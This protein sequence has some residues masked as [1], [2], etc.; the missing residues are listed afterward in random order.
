MLEK[1]VE[2]KDSVK[3]TFGLINKNVPVLSETEWQICENVLK[4]LRPFEEFTTRLSSE[5]SVNASEIIIFT[6]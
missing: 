6:N 3:T 1:F 4:M 2:M 5:K